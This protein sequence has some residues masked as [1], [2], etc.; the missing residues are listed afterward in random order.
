MGAKK[1]KID[2]NGK[3]DGTK[4]A[5]IVYKN[6]VQSVQSPEKIATVSTQRNLPRL[7]KIS[8]YL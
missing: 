1:R 3:K 2:S 4:K 6:I 7:E 8:K 5:R